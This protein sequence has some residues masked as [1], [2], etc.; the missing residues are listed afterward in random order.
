M[1]H[2]TSTNYTAQ[3]HACR[4]CKHGGP[5]RAW[6]AWAEG[7]SARSWPFQANSNSRWLTPYDITSSAR[8]MVL[9]EDRSTARLSAIVPFFLAFF[10]GALSG[11]CSVIA[12]HSTGSLGVRLPNTTALHVQLAC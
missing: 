4:L 7:Y 12:M 1:K 11:T 2:L 6:Y 5:Q 8:F 3:C 10:F 9:G